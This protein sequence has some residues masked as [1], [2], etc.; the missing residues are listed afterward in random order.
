MGNKTRWNNDEK[1]NGEWKEPMEKQQETKNNQ[2]MLDA[3][4]KN[5]ILI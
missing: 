1:R 3:E 4:Q 5:L 2:D